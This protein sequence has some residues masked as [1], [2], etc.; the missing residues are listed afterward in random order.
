MTQDALIRRVAYSVLCSLF[1]IWSFACLTAPAQAGL[2]GV[3]D[4]DFDWAV[5]GDPGNAPYDGR[6]NPPHSRPLVATGRGSVDYSYRISKLEITT[7]QWL[8]FVNAFAPRSAN[9]NFFLKPAIWGARSTFTPGVYELNPFISNAAQL[10]VL[11]INWRE[12]AMYANWLHNDKSLE[13]S[14]ITNGAYDTSTFGEKFDAQGRLVGFTDQRTHNPDAKFWIPTLDEWMKAAH[15]DP[16]RFG[17]GDGGWW[18]YSHSSDEPP[19]GGPPGV[20]EANTGFI[21]PEGAEFEIPL[22]SYPNV[23]SPWGLLDTAGGG[24]EWVE[25][26]FPIGDGRMHTGTSIGSLQPETRIFD[27]VWAF[28]VLD[29]NIA[30]GQSL[31]IASSAPAPNVLSALFI[32]TLA[33]TARRYR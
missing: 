8:E 3:P 33:C 2:I 17:P 28:N 27:A 10:P 14:A 21:L 22:G 13:M 4:Y 5:I 11:S 9:P 25:E 15:W 18:Q 24:A 19:V 26:V 23:Q 12:A 7:G 30:A 6:F 29:P 31:R 1:V 20:G 32:S 16:S